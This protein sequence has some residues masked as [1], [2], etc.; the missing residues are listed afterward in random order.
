MD[1]EGFFEDG[2]RLCISRA[3]QCEHGPAAAGRQFD[4]FAPDD[5]P[6]CEFDPAAEGQRGSAGKVDGQQGIAAAALFAADGD[7]Q[8]VF[9]GEADRFG[10]RKE[11]VSAVVEGVRRPGEVVPLFRLAGGI[12]R[13]DDEVGHRPVFAVADRKAEAA[14][15]RAVNHLQHQHVETA[16]ELGVMQEIVRH[17]PLRGVGRADKFAVQPGFE[18]VV[19]ADAEPDLPRLGRLDAAGGIDDHVVVYGAEPSVERDDR[20]FAFLREGLPDDRKGFVLF[21]APLVGRADSGDEF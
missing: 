2:K 12:V 21:E 20:G 8:R 7:A 10:E 11:R 19:A 16:P 4:R 3:G 1:F 15:V 6:A 13:P 5:R 9:S 17:D 14:A 18:I